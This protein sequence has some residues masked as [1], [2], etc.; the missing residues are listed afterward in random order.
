MLDV[1]SEIIGYDTYKQ[2]IDKQTE[3]GVELNDRTYASLYFI[4]STTTIEA[5]SSSTILR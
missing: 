4:N 5:V 1:V 3:G 2:N